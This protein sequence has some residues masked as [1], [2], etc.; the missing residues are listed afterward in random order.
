MHAVLRI[1]PQAETSQ[2]TPFAD[3]ASCK[4]LFS[5]TCHPIN[6]VNLPHRAEIMWDCCTL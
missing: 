5:L 1:V 2:A 6:H 3:S 4:V